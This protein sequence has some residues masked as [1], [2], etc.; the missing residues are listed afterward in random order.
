MGTITNT[1]GPEIRYEE[2][3]TGQLI[4]FSPGRPLPAGDQKAVAH[5]G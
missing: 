4:V 2:R 3:G 1:D 5:H